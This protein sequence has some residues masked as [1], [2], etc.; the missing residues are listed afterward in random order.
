MFAYNNILFIYGMYCR[1]GCLHQ[2]YY[3][4]TFVQKHT[5][6]LRHCIYILGVANIVTSRL[7]TYHSVLHIQQYSFPCI[8]LKEGYF[9][10][11][12]LGRRLLHDGSQLFVVSNEDNLLRFVTRQR[13]ETLRL[14]AHAAFIDDALRHVGG[15]LDA[16]TGAV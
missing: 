3:K 1:S 8:P 16:G 13:N 5:T 4:Q 10:T 14:R 7:I 6:V 11:E 12:L 9:Q 15:S 2:E